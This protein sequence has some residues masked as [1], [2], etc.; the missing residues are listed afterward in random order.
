[1]FGPTLPNGN[2][3]STQPYQ[4]SNQPGSYLFNT[5][6]NSQPPLVSYQQ[7]FGFQ[8][9]QTSTP[10]TSLGVGQNLMQQ[11]M[12]PRPSLMQQTTQQFIP[13]GQLLMPQTYGFPPSQPNPIEIA[14][15]IFTDILKIEHSG[16]PLSSINS[17]A[18]PIDFSNQGSRKA[19]YRQTEVEGAICHSINA[20]PEY[21]NTSLI[22]L[23]ARDYVMNNNTRPFPLA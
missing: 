10:R 23:R 1:M 7:P 20:M 16:F 15:H 4:Q 9:L 3:Y 11:T 13:T 12:N 22:E 18:N 17:Y 14:K 21:E 5:T 6:P 8:S 19:L 2:Y